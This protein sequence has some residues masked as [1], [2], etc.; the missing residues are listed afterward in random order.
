M[1]KY[2][3]QNGKKILGQIEQNIMIALG[4]SLNSTEE[5]YGYQ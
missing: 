1:G 5:G 4:I 3:M 2:K